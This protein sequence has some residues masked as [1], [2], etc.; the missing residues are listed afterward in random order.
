[1]DKDVK[2]NNKSEY[3]K[4][5]KIVVVFKWLLE[6]FIMPLI[7]GL[8][9]IP[10]QIKSEVETSFENYI[11]NNELENFHKIEGDINT[12]NKRVYYKIHPNEN[13]DPSKVVKLS[14]N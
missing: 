11:K 2:S 12:D 13:K 8:V 7:V 9:L 14:K 1:M 5:K 4:D 10:A 3:E 6:N